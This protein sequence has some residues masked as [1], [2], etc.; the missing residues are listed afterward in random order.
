MSNLLRI[1]CLVTVALLPLFSGTIC[2]AQEN[3]DTFQRPL[4]TVA[5]TD[6]P[7]VVDGVLDDPAWEDA[8]GFTGLIPIGADDISEHDTTVRATYTDERLYVACECHFDPST[9]LLGQPHP[10]D[11]GSPW[12][13][14]SVE[15]YISPDPQQPE[16]YYQII[17]SSAASIYDIHGGDK[18][19]SPDIEL[20]TTVSEGIWV[21]EASVPF[22]AFGVEAPEAGESWLIN[23]CRDVAAGGSAF[24]SWT[25]VAS[26][27]SEFE[28]FGEL[29][30][31]GKAPVI[32]IDSLGAPR[33][34]QL[35]V[36]AR[37][38]NHSDQRTT[39]ELQAWI[40]QPGT[41]LTKKGEEWAQFITGK[42][43]TASDR[44]I[45][46]PGHIGKLDVTTEFTDRELG[47]MDLTATLADGTVLY[48]QQFPLTVRPKTTVDL[49][50]VPIQQRLMVTVSGAYEDQVDPDGARAIVAVRQADEEITQTTVPLNEAETGT[51]LD[52]SEWAEGTYTIAVQIVD[53]TEVAG[54]AETTFEKTPTPE[55]VNNDLGKSRVIVP[56][57]TPMT[58]EN[59]AVSCWG[60]TTDFN[61]L[62]PSS[63]V[64]QGEELLAAP[65]TLQIG[66]D[67]QTATFDADDMQFSQQSED[68]AELVT[69]G[70]AAGVAA[71]IDWW[72][73]YDGF[74]WG[75]LTLDTPETIE[76]LSMEIPLSAE[77]AQ[78]T[79]G[80]PNG[81]HC[82]FNELLDGQELSWEFLPTVWVGSHDRGLCWFAESDQYYNPVS[83]DSVVELV[84]SDDGYVLRINIIGQ[85]T[86]IP[87]NFKIGFGLLGSPVKKLP[88]GYQML[89]IVW[90]PPP[91]DGLDWE[92][93][94]ET[95]DWGLLWWTGTYHKHL[96]A[97]FLT[98]E[99]VR[100]RVEMG[101]N[102]GVGVIHYIAPGTHTM[103][104]EEPQKY[105]EEWRLN[106]PDEFYIPKVDETYPRL[107]LNS[108]YADYLLAGID[109]MVSE[110]GLH[111]IYHDG[112]APSHCSND[113][114]GCGYRDAEGQMHRIRP[115]RAYREYHKRLATMLYHDNGIEDFFIYNH[116]SDICWLPTLTFVNAH[117]DGEQYLS[118]LNS[119]ANYADLFSLEEI[120]PEYVSTQW[121]IP[122]VF[123]NLCRLDGQGAA[124]PECTSTFLAYLLAH[125]IPYWG[126]R[127]YVPYNQQVHEIY[128]AFDT[129]NATFHPYWHTVEGFTV[130]CGPDVA[131]VSCYT[132]DTGGRLLVV[133]G[134]IT[135]SAQ[136]VAVTI[137]PGA[138][139]LAP[140]MSIQRN[141]PDD[142][143]AGLENS[144]LTMEI[145]P[146]GFAVTW[147]E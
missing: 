25:R 20:E 71:Q 97:P 103:A 132:H 76:H 134:N 68:R 131:P 141:V 47:L 23:F 13:D 133:A 61:G 35:A 124:S 90:W 67:G 128:A 104:Y 26:R 46:D 92:A 135:D 36:D 44:A 94:G 63:L 41:E 6:H 115:I 27:Y 11:E 4:L 87:E 112:G 120:R 96:T 49:Q 2:V 30:F 84:P 105:R 114:H 29:R 45:A 130:D 123:L 113:I 5:Q 17:L 42:L 56:P 86:E 70:S 7:P 144:M 78:M 8:A 111:G 143:Q 16:D 82:A 85:A 64:S 32:R 18:S 108:S 83:A 142:M 100:P 55:W 139:G 34:C 146:Y 38:I 65:I 33:Y 15:I 126:E 58:Y 74:T 50:P 116:T 51:S 140:Q 53:D 43:V 21:L 31:V 3:P 125:G 39:G 93:I 10:R 22:S 24:E 54:V 75:E 40:V 69:R 147:I 66:V 99:W 9:T 52:Y 107:C 91:S 145:P 48:T 73:E 12:A 14:D 137:D 117:L 19:W 138:L 81:R 122:T 110:F 80:T 59:T 109:H 77:V 89:D 79:H 72:M 119:G 129:D 127:M 37:I 57:Y 60:R 121:G 101:K 1:W 95:P 118:R 136:T 62:L 102:M 98:P 88:K 28:R 106:P